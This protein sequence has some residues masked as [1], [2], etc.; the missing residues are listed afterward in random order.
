[1][2]LACVSMGFVIKNPPE[3]QMKEFCELKHVSLSI[4]RYGCKS[5]NVLYPVCM[6][7]CRSSIQLPF[8]NIS[9][10]ESCRACV[11]NYVGRNIF[12]LECN[13]SAK[14]NYVELPLISSCKCQE[15]SCQQCYWTVLQI[16]LLCCSFWMLLKAEKSINVTALILRTDVDTE[17]KI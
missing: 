16:L 12:N 14:I 9:K 6:G 10:K 2:L 3:K 5:T 1:M 4:E 8:L 11:A 15:M 13:E 17:Q 7:Y